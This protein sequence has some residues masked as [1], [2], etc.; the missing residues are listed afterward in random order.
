MNARNTDGLMQ[1]G[2]GPAISR[3]WSQP[4]LSALGEVC[5]LTETGSM[6]NNEGGNEPVRAWI[7]CNIT[8]DNLNSTG[9]C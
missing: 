1:D 8:M 4:R 3:A 2:P 9:M 5:S 6:A 7:R